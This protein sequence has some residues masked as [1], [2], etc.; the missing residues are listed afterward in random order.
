MSHFLLPCVGRFGD[1][2]RAMGP[3]EASSVNWVGG[4]RRLHWLEK[5]RL[6]FITCGKA[7]TIELNNSW[8]VSPIRRRRCA[9]HFSH[10]P[11]KNE[12][13]V[14]GTTR[15]W[16]REWSRMRRVIYQLSDGLSSSLSLPFLLMVRRTNYSIPI[17]RDDELFVFVSNWNRISVADRCY[18]ASAGEPYSI[19]A[20][21][22]QYGKS[23]SCIERHIKKKKGDG[24]TRTNTLSACTLGWVEK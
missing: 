21:T 4:E 15:W 6:L 7:L 24:E 23:L 11:N 20:N 17:F 9:D 1:A 19:R 10:A 8:F 14:D 12:K 13:H 5:D 3:D 22:R 16:K 2:Y 18:N